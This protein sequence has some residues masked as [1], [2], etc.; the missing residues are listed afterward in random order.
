MQS[1]YGMIAVISCLTFVMMTALTFYDQLQPEQS[2]GHVFMMSV[3]YLF[4]LL[5]YI[6][7]F[8]FMAEANHSYQL[9][10]MRLHERFLQSKIETYERMERNAQQARRDFQHH[11]MVV[12]E[13]A[14]QGKCAEILTYLREYERIEGVGSDRK[15]CANHVVNSLISAYVKKAE[16]DGIELKT[17]LRLKVT[18][19]I[20]DVDLVS[21]L[22]NMM[23]NAFRGCMEVE[24]KPKL[25]ELEIQQKNSVL[26]LV[27]RN[28][29][30]EE[31][32]FM[33][34][35]PRAR[36]HEGIGVE[37]I[38][39]T[40]AK[41]DGSADFHTAKGMFTCRVLL[42]ECDQIEEQRKDQ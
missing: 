24:G 33:D 36:D 32:L 27:C 7:L 14:E 17:L 1:G 23:E 2:A 11:I 26:L 30:A 21:V 6:L 16:Q 35:L 22:A 19:R 38:I 37:S 4:M 42:N 41:Y 10:Q 31:V 12:M 34:G 39:R 9:R 15:Y 5:V 29:C 18:P 40:A 20:S 28:T 8:H 3:S 25:V 13:L